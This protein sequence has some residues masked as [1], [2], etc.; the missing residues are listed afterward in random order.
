MEF[1]ILY[2]ELVNSTEMIRALIKDID[3]EQ[4]QAR[5]DAESWS[6]LEVICHLY[7]EECE[8]F[9]EHLDFILN[10]Q[11]EEWH[12]IDP[13]AWVTERKYNEKNFIDMQSKFARQDR[14]LGIIPPAAI[15]PRIRPS[16]A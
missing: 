14:S 2:Q 9:R 6:M 3:Q 12:A 15:P 5:P 1:Q 7:D 13:Q 11:K 4:A 16:M 8:D 10:R